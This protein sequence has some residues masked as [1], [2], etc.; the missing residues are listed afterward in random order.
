MKFD[1]N[2]EAFKALGEADND[3][4]NERFEQAQ[5]DQW[6]QKYH[7]QPIAGSM[8]SIAGFVHHEG[9]YHIFYQWS[10]FA[11]KR[12]RCL[13][14]VTSDDLV[15]FEN[16]GIV[17]MLSD[18]AYSG[19]AFVMEEDI[20]LYH[21]EVRSNT[22]YQQYTPFTTQ[23]GA[24]HP[25]RTVPVIKGVPP[26]YGWLM[27][28]PK[29]WHEDG[30]HFMLLGAASPGDYGRLLVFE[31]ETP[32]SFEY[33]GE[34]KTG[35]DQFGFM[36]EAPDYF[37]LDGHQVF[38]FC[39]QG[40][41]KYKN[42]YWNIYQSGYI[43]GEADCEALTLD[44]GPFHELDHGFDFY[45]PKTLLNGNGERLMIGWMGMKETAYPT[46][47]AWSHCLTLPRELSIEEGRLKQRP[48]ASLRKLREAEMTAEGYFNHRPKKVRDFYGDSYELVMDILE[49]DATRIHIDLR[50]S[51]KEQTSLIYKTDT[52]TLILDTA[53][54]GAMPENVDG[55]DRKVVLDSPLAS[56]HIFVDV[57]S[58]E[59]FANDGEAV[60]T[61][62]I[63]P[64][65]RATGMEVS[66]EI[67][68]CHVK[69]TRY[70]LKQLSLKPV[71]DHR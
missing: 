35:L 69:M 1:S 39:P 50:V 12:T 37:E 9:L 68:S 54:S 61:A 7:V 58:I 19:S 49:N 63:F 38:M 65:D 26:E 18:G 17:K 44:H 11:D 20:H 24:L 31:G 36:W 53:F 6:R 14:H 13:Y 62:R 15:Y 3:S 57:S 60:M 55:T 40:L 21:T 10:P 30:R 51:R 48:A 46:G 23:A 71:L 4:L 29:V 32:S 5:D 25:G 2:T 67:G 34:L 56:L 64:S 28:D 16:R 59:I 52:Q 22:V 33:R 42:S 47:E 41:D 70:S 45:A 8:N 43:I 27:K 66:T